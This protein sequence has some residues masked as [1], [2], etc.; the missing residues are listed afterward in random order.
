MD[1]NDTM[2]ISSASADSALGRY[3]YIIGVGV[4]LLAGLAVAGFYID[5]DRPVSVA[6]SDI[7]VGEDEGPGG[8]L[9]L[10][11]IGFEADARASLYQLDPQSQKLTLT[12]GDANYNLTESVSR[13]QDLKA[14]MSVVSEN[15]IE[16]I[17]MPQLYVQKGNSAPLQIT[18][19]QTYQKR[20][21]R[22]NSLGDRIAFMAQADKSELSMSLYDWSVYVTDFDGNET[23]VGTGAY[24]HWLPDGVSLLVL[25]SDGLHLIDTETNTQTKVW[26]TVGGDVLLNTKISLADDGSKIAWSAPDLGTVSIIEV[27]S[28]GPFEGRLTHTINTHAFWSAFSPGGDKLALQAVDWDTL[29]TDPKPRVEMYDLETKQQMVLFDLKDFDQTEMYITDWK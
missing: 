4:A 1:E 24:P 14:Y 3:K 12:K 16:G 13:T 23:N 11:L 19:S 7:A 2:P 15:L 29:R 26:S 20:L 10:T 25:R 28:W 17:S 22:L 8:N 21:P 27:T 6:E 9:H 5:S 18:T